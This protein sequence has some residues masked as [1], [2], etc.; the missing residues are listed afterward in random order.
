MID[1][2]NNA[3][4]LKR[5]AAWILAGFLLVAAYFLVMEHRAHLSGWLQYLP[6]LLVLACPLMHIFMHRGHGHHGAR[7]PPR[8]RDTPGDE[9]TP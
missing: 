8:T 7:T 6:L 4:R 3:A 2:Q 9:L 5:R 1:R